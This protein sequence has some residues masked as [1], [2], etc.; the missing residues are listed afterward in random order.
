MGFVEAAALVLVP[1]IAALLLDEGPVYSAILAGVSVAVA[2]VL[3][4]LASFGILPLLVGQAQ[5][6]VTGAVATASVA[7]RAMAIMLALLLFLS[8]SVETWQAFGT[9]AGWRFG[10]VLILFGL[11]ALVV[12]L[13]GLRQERRR[14]LAP[15]HDP[16]LD[17]RARA[18]PA[19][20]LVRGGVRP[21]FPDLGPVARFNLGLA[22]V[23]SLALRVV[24]VSAAVGV[25]FLLFA[26]LVID[27]QLTNSWVGEDPNFLWSLSIADREVVISAAAIGVATVLGAFAGLYFTVVAVGDAQNRKEFVEDEIERLSR[28][29]AAWAFYRGHLDRRQAGAG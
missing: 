16:R 12:L 22:M 17:S 4:A 21:H 29:M 11:L 5:H 6:A 7:V 28:V 19:A 20:P 1:P 8:L 9:L 3:Y 26:I 27:R 23:I 15:E 13:A 25:L 2:V 24:A 14:L 18:T 10:G